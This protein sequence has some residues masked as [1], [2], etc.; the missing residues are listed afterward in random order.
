V[1]AVTTGDAILP[2]NCSRWRAASGNVRV[3]GGVAWEK[4]AFSAVT[5]GRLLEL[6]LLRRD[7]GLPTRR[8]SGADA[9]LLRSARR[10]LL[11]E[12]IPESEITSANRSRR[13]A[14]RAAGARP[15]RF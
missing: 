12:A 3:G 8:G 2:D 4:Y 5:R 15:R 9:I 11:V 6:F 7:D 13:A 1:F 14:C 10:F